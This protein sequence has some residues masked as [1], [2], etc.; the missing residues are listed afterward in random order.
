M[1]G[2]P[3][4]TG[5]SEK[6]TANDPLSAQRR[7]S[8]AASSGSHS[9]MRVHGISRPAPAPP[10]HSS[11]IQSLYAWTHRS[12]SSLSSRSRNVC[13]Q[14]PGKL[15]KHRLASVWFASMAARRAVWS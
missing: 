7:I 5:L 14:K 2:R 13:P 3:S 11:I 15:G 9:G 4:G 10:H 12:A 8:A 1:L 6:A